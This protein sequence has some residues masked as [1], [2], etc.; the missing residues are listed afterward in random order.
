MSMKAGTR[1]SR[2]IRHIESYG[3]GKKYRDCWDSLMDWKRRSP[4]IHL[5][6][7]LCIALIVFGGIPVGRADEEKSTT[8]DVREDLDPS[9]LTVQRI[10]SGSDFKNKSFGPARWLSHG[11]GYT[12]L[13]ESP[14]H[15]GRKDIVAYDPGGGDRSVLVSATDLIPKDQEKPL[16]IKNYAWSDDRTKLLIYTNSVKVWRQETRGD[17]WLFDIAAKRLRKLGGDADESRMMF[18]KFSPDGKRVGYVYRNNLYLQDLESMEISRLTDTGSESIINGT[19]DWVY[20]EE[21]GVRDGWRFSPD[22]RFIAFWNFDTDGVKEFQLI[23]YTKSRYPEITSYKYPK[24]GETN[25]ACRIGVISVDGGETQWVKLPGDLRDN[26][27]PRMDWI[28]GTNRIVLQRLNR[29]QNTNQLMVSDVTCDAGGTVAVSPLKTIL[30]ENDDAW[31]DV[32]D[33]M[34][35]IDDGERF[36]WTSQRDGWRHLYL[37]SAD[38]KKMVLLTPGEFDVI[39]VV[40]IDDHDGWV[41]F[42]AS[43]DN[44]GQRYLF[45]SSLDGTGEIQS[46]TPDDQRGTHSYQISDDARWAI[47]TF[48]SFDQPPV[49]DLVR[50]PGH[51][52]VRVLEDNA[53]LQA[54]FAEV[55]RGT[56]EFFQIEI[57]DG[58]TLDGWCLKP[59][60]FDPQQKYPLFI[61]V[62]GEPAGQTVLDRWNGKRNLWHRMIAEQGYVVVSVDNRGTPAPRGR[63]W[64]KSVYRQIGILA[65]SDQAAAVRA[66]TRQWSFIDTDRVGIWGWSGGGSMSLNAIFRYPDLYHTAMAIAFVSEQ[67]NYDTLYQERFMGLPED[68][69]QGYKNGSPITFAQQLKGNLLLVYGTGDDNCH[70]QNCQMLINE[71]VKHHKPFSMMAYP[72]RSHSISEGKGTTRH[73]F[74]LLTRYLNQNLPPG[75]K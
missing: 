52:S 55:D 46:L 23:N 71:L 32:H 30:V 50:L 60:D 40:K 4:M 13:E 54:A 27:V 68:N 7:M 43:P 73:L 41:Y 69:P 53:E 2:Q 17:Y 28:P 24:V 9:R 36:T 48:S 1:D 70:Y 72:N 25:S 3:N 75:P 66:M 14:D 39:R 5:S 12:T 61:F 59:A 18:A 26:Y 34:K 64:R 16:E 47:H 58:V 42:I 11:G 19:A 67:Q 37:V 6:R 57:G 63:A 35:W 74:E 10:Y 51:Q 29:L 62:Y 65:S 38:G 49:I 44:A 20:E 8:G 56:T 31:V 45:R 22:G 15:K 33:D 21:F